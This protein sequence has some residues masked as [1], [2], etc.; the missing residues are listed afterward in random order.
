MNKV[1]KQPYKKPQ[2]V[3][4]LEALAWE[5]KRQ[6]FPDVPD[7]ILVSEKYRD[8]RQTDLPGASLPIYGCAVARQS[9]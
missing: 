9:A 3:K 8:V 6:R 1:K 7:Y 4:D 2:A 5:V